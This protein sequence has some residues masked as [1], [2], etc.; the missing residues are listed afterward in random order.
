MK[1]V[2]DIDGVL[3]PHGGVIEDDFCRFFVEWMDNKNVSVVSGSS[4]SRICQVLSET[5][6]NKLWTIFSCNGTK[7]HRNKKEIYSMDVIWPQDLFSDMNMLMEYS[8][9]NPKLR[10]GNHIE[11]RETAINFSVL[12]RNASEL[13]R[14]KYSEWD[15]TFRERKTICEYINENFP[16]LECSIGGAISVD[17]TKK[18]FGK[19]LILDY[20]DG[21]ITFFGDRC[22]PGGNDYTLS[23]KL[24]EK[25]QKVYQIENYGEVIDILR[26][27]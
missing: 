11:N 4:F 3:V 9:W 21:D 14:K 16:E 13:N 26:R 18:G 22:Y 25:N 27:I 20:M 10:F 8:K 19:H 7:G 6:I 1:Y 17:I 5:I 2:F 15:S 12:G 23:E 24:K